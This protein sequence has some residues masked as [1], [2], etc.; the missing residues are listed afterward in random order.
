MLLSDVFHF[1]CHI[2]SFYVI[3]ASP[4]I[5][6]CRFSYAVNTLSAGSAMYLRPLVRSAGKIRIPWDIDAIPDYDALYQDS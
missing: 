3:H 5:L 1:L 2:E 4:I 6:C